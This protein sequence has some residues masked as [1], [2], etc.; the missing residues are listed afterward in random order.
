[1]E[2]DASAAAYFWA[3]AAI[4]GG[5]A[6]VRGLSPASPQGD[7]GFAQVLGGMGC[8]VR[9]GADGLE[10]T[11]PAS[12]ALRGVSVSLNAMPDTVQTLAVTALFADGPTEIRDVANLRVKETDRLAAL[13]TELRRFGA[14]VQEGRDGLRIQPPARPP[15]ERVEVSTYDDHRMAMSFAIAGLRHPVRIR[16]AG[17][18][19]KSF[20]GFFDVLSAA[21]AG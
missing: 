7:V 14:D 9:A 8:G 21:L 5:R 4:S 1:V 6:C 18:V 16:E 15:R 17:C 10:V 3:A 2:P 19:S 12:G 11:G 20:P 13:A